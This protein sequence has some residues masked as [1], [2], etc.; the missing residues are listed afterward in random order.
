ML[1]VC[2]LVIRTSGSGSCFLHDICPLFSS[3]SYAIRLDDSW[4]FYLFKIAHVDL[5]AFEHFFICLICCHAIFFYTLYDT[6]QLCFCIHGFSPIYLKLSASIVL[7][8]CG[9]RSFEYYRILALHSHGL[10][11]VIL[12]SFEHYLTFIFFS[13][14][15]VAFLVVF[16]SQWWAFSLYF[17]YA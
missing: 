11:A 13:R 3:H 6:D 10:L 14:G 2:G 8:I 1:I 12:I 4:D 17:I 15:S 7:R 5:G 16:L 9:R